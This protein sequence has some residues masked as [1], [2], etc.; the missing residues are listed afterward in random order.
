MFDLTQLTTLKLPFY[1]TSVLKL[2]SIDNVCVSMPELGSA[3]RLIL[4]GGSNLVVLEP[5]FDGVVLRP[6][7]KLFEVKEI[8]TD[9][10]LEVGAGHQWHETVMQTLEH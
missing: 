10:F 5:E 1:A 2:S 9:I 6:E 8:G 3:P 4:S 7:I